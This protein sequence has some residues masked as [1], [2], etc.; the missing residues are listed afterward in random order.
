MAEMTQRGNMALRYWRTRRGL[1]LA[2]LARAAGV[3]KATLFY[4]E[5]GQVSPLMRTLRK[6]AGAL[7]VP[8]TALMD[9]YA[10]GSPDEEAG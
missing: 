1:S 8:V 7:E 4:W 10:A 5:H 6:V 9:P 2:E 3:S